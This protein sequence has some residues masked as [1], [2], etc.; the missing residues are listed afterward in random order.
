MKEYTDYIHQ[1]E[2]YTVRCK[3]YVNYT[4]QA[5]MF[6]A[7]NNASGYLLREGVIKIA[8]AP[9][10]IFNTNGLIRSFWYVLL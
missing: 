3:K 5:K 1:L 9:G 2:N 6:F 10:G 7:N 4:K 8:G